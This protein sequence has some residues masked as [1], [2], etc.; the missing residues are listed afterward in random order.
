MGATH[1][2]HWF[3]PLNGKTAKKNDAFIE[4]SSDNEPIAKFSGDQLI[5]NE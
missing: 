1:F 3:Q 2:C 4:R 5:K